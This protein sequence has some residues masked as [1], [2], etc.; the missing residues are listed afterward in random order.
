MENRTTIGCQ[1]DEKLWPESDSSIFAVTIN[2]IAFL[3]CRHCVSVDD[4]GLCAFPEEAMSP[5]KAWHYLVIIIH[6]L[7]CARC[8]NPIGNLQSSSAT[9]C[10]FKVG[11]G[12]SLQVTVYKTWSCAGMDSW[13]EEWWQ[14][15]YLDYRVWSFVYR[16]YTLVLMPLLLEALV[17]V[18][19]TATDIQQT[20]IRDGKSILTSTIG[21]P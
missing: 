8:Y 10:S 15:R 9:L 11:F 3:R 12:Y 17:Y 5:S 13:W 16:V 14:W 21:F 6:R 7:T 20:Y 4:S 18:H 1:T 2:I 19:F